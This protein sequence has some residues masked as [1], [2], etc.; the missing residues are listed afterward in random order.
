ME[1][2]QESTRQT[3]ISFKEEGNK[4]YNQGE[5]EN[6]KT[7]YTEAITL[8]P[9]HEQ[10]HIFYCN[11]AACNLQLKLY[12]AVID[13]TTSAISTNPTYTKAVLRRAQA[14]QA[15]DKLSEA[16]TD[17]ETV[18]SQDPSLKEATE[19]IPKLKE[20]IRIKQEKE[21]AEMMGKLKDF[22][23]TLLGKF[24]F[25]VDNFQMQKDDTTGGYNLQFNNN[26]P[27]PSTNT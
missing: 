5:Y 2:G 24:G 13:D 18:Q 10:V 15:L 27:K 1:E 6:A 9:D 26:N 22:G 19:A 7:S 8:D 20:E 14:Y 25:S 21:T 11:R 16:L 4:L 17:Y 3:A 23:N 12:Q